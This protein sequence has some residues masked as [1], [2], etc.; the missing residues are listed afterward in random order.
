MALPEEKLHVV[1][2]F[3]PLR[4]IKSRAAN[5]NL[6]SNSL[7]SVIFAKL[8]LEKLNSY[9]SNLSSDLQIFLE[10]ELELG[11]KFR[12]PVLNPCT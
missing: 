4:L 2:L 3:M 1:Y 6:K 9:N 8:E 10:L 7:N 11:E 12:S 5:S